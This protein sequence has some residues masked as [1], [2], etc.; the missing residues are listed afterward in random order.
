M[1]YREGATFSDDRRY[2][3]RLWR[4]WDDDLMPVL[5]LLLN[6][7]TATAFEN[8]PTVSRCITRASQLGFG[9]VEVCNIYAYRSTDP[10]ALYE[11]EDPV[12]PENLDEIQAAATMCKLVILGWGAHG[13]KVSPN[14]P[15]MV[16]RAVSNRDLFTLGVNKDGQPKHPLY[17]KYDLNPQ[18][19]NP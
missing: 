1:T 19:Y 2:R 4:R 14:W 9:G 10:K 8:D 18:R 7:S 15:G 17:V 11:A 5:F 13:E 3:Y 6:P 12:G 16:V